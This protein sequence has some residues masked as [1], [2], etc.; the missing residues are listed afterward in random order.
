[1]SR[2]FFLIFIAGYSGWQMPRFL[3]RMIARSEL[4]R[5][6]FLG[7]TGFFEQ[8][9]TRFGLANPYRDE[10]FDEVFHDE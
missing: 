4:H 9:G 1:M 2:I 5:A 8:D 6:W 7:A 3:R 10:I